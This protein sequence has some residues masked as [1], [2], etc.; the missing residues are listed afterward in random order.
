MKKIYMVNTEGYCTQE[1][2][3]WDFIKSMNLDKEYNIGILLSL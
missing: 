1:K 2:L 3:Y